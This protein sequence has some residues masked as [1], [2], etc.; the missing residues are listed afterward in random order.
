MSL[1]AKITY[2]NTSDLE[3]EINNMVSNNPDFELNNLAIYAEITPYSYIPLKS[4]VDENEKKIRIRSIDTLD[5]LGMNLYLGS[6]HQFIHQK[7]I[8]DKT[9]YKL[10]LPMSFKTAWNTH[11]FVIFQNGYLMNSGLFSYVMPLLTNNYLKK[12]IYSTVKFTKGSRVDVF[13]IE[14]D[15]DFTQ[16]PVS[17][18]VYLGAAK[19]IPRK[20]NER[21]I[22]IPYPNEKFKFTSFFVFNKNGEYLDN[23]LDYVVSYDRS[24]ITLRTQSL[25]RANTDYLIFAFP[26]LAKE[27]EN[28]EIPEENYIALTGTPYFS[29]SYSL[30]TK[31]NET[32]LVT[33]YPIF[34]EYYLTKKNFLLF[35][36]GEFIDPDRFE[37][38]SNDTIRFIDENYKA[39]CNNI[40]FTMIIFNDDSDHT[41]HRI[42][43]D[44]KIVKF[45]NPEDN[46]TEFNLYAY[47]GREYRS[48]LILQNNKILS[49]YEYDEES[50][51]VTFKHPINGELTVIFFSSQV[52]NSQQEGIL[53][54]TEFPCNPNLDEGTLFPEEYRNNNFKQPVI[55]LFLDGVYVGPNRCKI[56]NDTIFL[57]KIYYESDE[58][59]NPINLSH[60]KFTMLV[61]V[62]NYKY[63]QVL[64]NEE[65]IQD[66]IDLQSDLEYNYNQTAYFYSR[67]SDVVIQR[68]IIN[69]SDNFNK[70]P[71]SYRYLLLFDSTGLWVDPTRFE[72]NNNN[73]LSL[74]YPSDQ[75][76]SYRKIYHAVTFDDKLRNEKYNPPNIIF[77]QVIAT[78]DNQSVFRI[79][80]SDIRCISFLVF[81]NNKLLNKEYNYIIAHNN[82]VLQYKRDYLN[83]GESLTFVFVDAYT[84]NGQEN[85][86]I[87]T[88]FECRLNSPTDI[89][90]NFL[91]YRF[92]PD[93]IILFLNG[94]YLPPDKYRIED[95]CI[96][97]DG[98]IGLNELAERMLTMVYLYTIPTSLKD[99]EYPIPLYPSTITSDDTITKPVKKRYIPEDDPLDYSGFYFAMY[100]SELF[101]ENERIRYDDGFDYFTLKKNNFLLFGNSTFIHPI[102][103][104]IINNKTLKM[105]EARDAY[106]TRWTHYNMIIPFNK[107]AHRIYREDYVQPDFKIIEFV[108]TTVTKEFEFPVL[109]KAYENVMMFRNSLI[110]SLYDE[111][112]FI[113]NDVD[114]KFKI[115][116]E[117]DWIPANTTVTLIFFKS[118]TN[119]DK[120]L[121][122]VQETFPCLDLETRIPERIYRYHNQ[123]FNKSKLLL[124]LNGTFVHPARYSLADNV[125][126]LRE[127]E[128]IDIDHDHTYTIVYLDTVDNDTYDME[129]IPI[130]ETFEKELDDIVFEEYVVKPNA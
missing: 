12:F 47:A 11:K 13:Y 7:Y 21:L 18:D 106:H 99:Y 5:F 34:N 49:D 9:T 95:Q 41:E 116:H 54:Q 30:D 130:D 53:Y 115:V 62:S 50:K 57:D 51:R 17:R 25:E 36:N 71:I 129:R 27:I 29:Y 80:A 98:Y 119:T 68:G 117:A 90:Q 122:L 93:N 88:S 6:K 59:G 52:N 19:Y 97:L 48:F 14:T 124:F 38:Y 78:E 72:V 67:T 92:N 76:A 101:D 85:R 28:I 123:K 61:L 121:I 69:F 43:R 20:N 107:T 3:N 91:N 24:Y 60:S 63:N 39:L 35:G 42:P 104:N 32:G 83:T 15:D 100:T 8:I 79:P 125:I 82:I 10:E 55:L 56:R 126:C 65:Q 26:H 96:L 44:Y 94:L 86:F 81:K 31:Y 77:K 128:D 102:R 40:N 118:T 22:P 113:I 58:R 84:R 74:V 4:Y 64:F 16:V 1:D 89:P 2:T 73:Q 110:V 127:E 87:Q 109:D 108:T 70:Y 105:V 66:L 23:P 46:Q 112:R 45:T 33:F 114:H 120:K 37:V 75:E 103:Y 111:D